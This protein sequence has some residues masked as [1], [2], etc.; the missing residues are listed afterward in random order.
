M[1][2]AGSWKQQPAFSMG[3]KTTYIATRKIRLQRRFQSHIQNPPQRRFM[4]TEKRWML[5]NPVTFLVEI[6]KMASFPSL[7]FGNHSVR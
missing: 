1:I 5:R 7:V 2:R 3:V 6:E 4:M